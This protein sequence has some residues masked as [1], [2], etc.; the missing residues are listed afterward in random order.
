MKISKSSEAVLIAGVWFVCGG[1]CARARACAHVCKYACFLRP[2]SRNFHEILVGICD[3]PTPS[4]KYPTLKASCA[5]SHC[6]AD[7]SCV[8]TLFSSHECQHQVSGLLSTAI[9]ASLGR[10]MVWWSGEGAL[11]QIVRVWSQLLPFTSCV[12]A[13]YPNFSV[14]QFCSSLKYYSLLKF[15]VTLCF[16]REFLVI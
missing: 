10:D 9:T 12:K 16:L 2:G 4:A 15:L 1:V 13:R 8:I 3:R 14:A 7:H 6:G 11:D 5:S